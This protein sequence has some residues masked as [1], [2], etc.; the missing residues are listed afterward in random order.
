[1]GTLGAITH[2]SVICEGMR[3]IR[4]IRR[5]KYKRQS[6]EEREVRK[7][8]VEGYLRDPKGGGQVQVSCAPSPAMTTRHGLLALHYRA[9]LSLSLRPDRGRT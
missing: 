1:V 3:P 2:P 9:V 6:W 4:H 5:D 7:A 8:G